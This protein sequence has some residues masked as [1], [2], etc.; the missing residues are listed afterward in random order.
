[1]K[2][3]L[4]AVIRGNFHE[5]TRSA[6]KILNKMNTTVGN[7][8]IEACHILDVKLYIV[9][10]IPD[11]GSVILY[12][13]ALVTNVCLIFTTL[14]FNGVT[15]AT[16][17]KS[18]KLREKKP[19]FLIMI[20]SMVDLANVVFFMTLS[21]M[22]LGCNLSGTTSCAIVFLAK[23]VGSLTFFYSMAAM[24]MMN[25]ERYFGAL[26]P[27]FHRT[28]VTKRRL[29]KCFV[30]ISSLE[31]LL[32]LGGNILFG[33]RMTK[34]IYSGNLLLFLFVTAFVHT[35]IV[36]AVMKKKRLPGLGCVSDNALETKN[37]E[38][39]ARFMKQIK[40]AKSCFLV[41]FISYV[42]SLPGIIMFGGLLNAEVNFFVI[43]LRKFSSLL[44]M[45]NSTLNSLIFFWRNTVLRKEGLILIRNLV[46]RQL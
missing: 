19:N 45:L 21:A 25:L 29:L 44:I 33:E 23:T 37:M 17:W 35:R 11:K 31:T 27:I 26:Y 34:L 13:F 1:M 2:G 8:F 7:V 39:K 46:K 28:K 5:D 42:C 14:F 20:Q 36:W 12:V 43:T 38:K 6:I 3:N 16:I 18:D 15:V 22:V 4:L 32:Y 30:A 41:V 9:I 40:I 10:K 24:W